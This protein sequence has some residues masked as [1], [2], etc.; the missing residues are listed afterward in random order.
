MQDNCFCFPYVSIRADRAMEALRV[1]VDNLQWEVNRLDAENQMLRAQDVKASKQVDLELEIEQLKQNASK[2]TKELQS[3]KE[4]LATKEVDFV[5][6]ITG[7]TPKVWRK[8]AAIR[9][10]LQ[11]L[12]DNAGKHTFSRQNFCDGT[13]N[14]WHHYNCFVHLIHYHPPYGIVFHLCAHRII[15][16]IAQYVFN[17]FV[18]GYQ[19]PQNFTQSFLMKYRQV[20]HSLIYYLLLLSSN[21]KFCH[22]THIE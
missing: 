1:Q 5:E 17:T 12:C 11:D 21:F 22:L 9:G 18:Y 10:F 8:I 4:V 19:K 7:T 15:E 13:R 14:S 2:A 20:R 16:Y 3:L 6:E